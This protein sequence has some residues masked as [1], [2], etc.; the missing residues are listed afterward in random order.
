MHNYK[1]KMIDLGDN[2]MTGKSYTMIYAILVL[3]TIKYSIQTPIFFIAM[4]I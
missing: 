3:S 4:N 2:I 1:N